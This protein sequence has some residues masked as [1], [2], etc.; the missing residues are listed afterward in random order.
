M[1]V[2]PQS[3]VLFDHVPSVDVTLVADLNSSTGYFLV[4]VY[5]LQMDSNL[6]LENSVISKL[7]FPKYSFLFYFFF[8]KLI[9]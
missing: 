2:A 1:E 9:R 3:A 4:F 6:E 5:I 8:F 7:N